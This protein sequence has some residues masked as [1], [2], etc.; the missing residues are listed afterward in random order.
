MLQTGASYPPPGIRAMADGLLMPLFW[1]VVDTADYWLMQARLG[2]VDA[3]CDPEPPRMADEIREA[4]RDRVK[5][6]FPEIEVDTPTLAV[7]RF[8]LQEP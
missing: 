8:G 4:D 2:I 1:R 5:K 7:S 3:V 6:G